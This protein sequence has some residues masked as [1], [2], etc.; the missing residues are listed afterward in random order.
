MPK[1]SHL[2]R[3][4]FYGLLFASALFAIEGL[5][6]AMSE[7]NVTLW[8]IPFNL[9]VG[10]PL[11]FVLG[12]FCA[13][14][15]GGW[16]TD[17]PG[18]DRG[19]QVL[20]QWSWDDSPEKLASRTGWLV[21]LVA[22]F[23][24]WSALTIF[25]SR[26]ITL[27]IATPMLAGLLLVMLQLLVGLS[28]AA[29]SAFFARSLSGLLVF[30]ERVHPYASYLTRPA[31]FLAY[32]VCC[33]L[34]SGIVAWYLF[35][36]VLEA[37]PWNFAVAPMAALAVTAAVSFLL[38]GHR[39]RLRGA[40][41][42]LTA[43]LAI[44]SVFSL[45][46]PMRLEQARQIFA[47]QSSIV[48]AWYNVVH[49]RLDFDGDGSISFY[50]GGDCA[51]FDAERGPHQLEIIGDG[52]DQNCSGSDLIV[53][54]TEFHPGS[55]SHPRPEDI[56]ERPHIIWI[57]TDALSFSNTTV[58]GYDRNTTPHLAAWAE[59]ATVFDSAF[60]TSSSTR[61]A[62]PGLVASLYN[63]QIPMRDKRRHPYDYA[64]G[65]VTVGSVFKDAG[66]RTVFIPGSRYFVNWKGFQR[67]FDEVDTT[68]FA[69]AADPAH[70]APEMTASALRVLEEH[71]PDDRPLFLW[72][73]YFD[74][75]GP[76]VVPSGGKVFGTRNTRQ[77]RFD[78]ELHF[79]DR[80]WGKLIEAVEARFAPDEYLMLFT[81]DHGEA[82]DENHPRHPHG[83]TIHTRPLHVP[84]IIQGPAQRGVRVSGLTGHLDVLPTLANVIGVDPLD[85]WQGESL[86]PV[87]FEGDPI[88]KTV[89]YSLHYIPEGVK[90]GEDGFEMWGVRTDEFYYFENHR[91]NERRMVRWREDPLDQ[92]DL[93]RKL[94]QEAEIYRYVAAEKGQW[95]RDHEEGLTRAVRPGSGNPKGKGR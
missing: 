9:G 30:L 7:A 67:G 38:R 40:N 48:S 80:H 8:M 95:W 22:S 35:P 58:G 64:D 31:S 86:V 89:V 53:D 66:Y 70:P 52:I 68:S 15:A 88:E 34:A 74:H 27:A 63:S 19:F 76:Y 37:L 73:H 13:L 94:R 39:S 85:V 91:R 36:A 71:D 42:V 47:G 43:V 10:A 55:K 24:I 69:S 25:I 79:A 23:L 11:A 65:V 56:A 87:L 44:L 61:L 59:R 78:S 26:R 46:L 41:V 28:L 29:I 84:L 81:S 82:F 90:R 92:H 72:I 77:D 83:F 1:L 45:F 57:T 6:L 18:R 21:T 5:L 49:S 32:L 33:V 62:M 50:A 17:L 4:W 51:P 3:G 54:P 93:S 2:I 60:S 16:A 75:H 20:R 14:T 12:T